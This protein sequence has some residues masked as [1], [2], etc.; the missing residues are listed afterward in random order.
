MPVVDY[1]EPDKKNK[2]ESPHPAGPSFQNDVEG[3]SS[4]PFP[5]LTLKSLD[6]KEPNPPK[7]EAEPETATD[8]VDPFEG[9]TLKSIGIKESDHPLEDVYRSG[10]KPDEMAA[11]I[12]YS[13]KTGNPVSAIL[14]DEKMYNAAINPAP[15]FDALEGR[16]PGTYEFV[17]GNPAHMA[18]SADSLSEMGALE[19][20]MTLWSEQYGYG[21]KQLEAH[22]LA[23]Q[24][25]TGE[26]RNGAVLSRAR[27]LL[28]DERTLRA[29][30]TGEEMLSATAEL[31]PMTVGGMASLARM[32]VNRPWQ[33]EAVSEGGGFISFDPDEPAHIHVDQDFGAAKQLFDPSEGNAGPIMFAY[34]QEA[35]GAFLE[36]M[37]EVDKHGLHLTMEQIEAGAHTVGL[38]N[39]ALESVQLGVVLKNIPG[40]KQLLS[41]AVR[42]TV[43][44]KLKDPAFWKVIGKNALGFAG[45]VGAEVGTEVLQEITNIAVAEF[46]KSLSNKRDGREFDPATFEEIKTRLGEIASKTAMGMPLMIGPGRAVNTT[47]DVITT[48]NAK[49]AKVA[50]REFVEKVGEKLSEMPVTER[51]PETVEEF[52]SHIGARHSIPEALYI[53]GEEIKILFQDAVES[54]TMTEEQVDTVLEEVGIKKDVL[55]E[56]AEKGKFVTLETPKIARLINTPVWEGVTQAVT[57]D[58]RSEISEMVENVDAAFENEQEQALWNK[59]QEFK[60]GLVESG[61][62]T[63]DK[64]RAVTELLGRYLNK[65]QKNYDADVIEYMDDL[66]LRRRPFSE[67]VAEWRELVSRGEMEALGFDEDGKPL[68]VDQVEEHFDPEVA[69]VQAQRMQQALVESLPEA[70]TGEEMADAVDGLIDDGVL[71]EDMVDNSG[72]WEW[73]EEKD[74]A[75]RQDVVDYLD[76]LIQA[77]G[78]GALF[79]NQYT[80]PPITLHD[81]AIPRLGDMADVFYIDQKDFPPPPPPPRRKRKRRPSPKIIKDQLQY[82]H[83]ASTADGY[84]I[85]FNEK[86]RNHVLKFDLARYNM[87]SKIKE[88]LEASV[89]GGKSEAEHDL[90]DVAAGTVKLGDYSLFPSLWFYTWVDLAGDLY[91]VRLQVKKLFT[92]DYVLYDVQPQKI[93]Q[94]SAARLAW[95]S[96]PSRT[97]GRYTNPA[98]LRIHELIENSKHAPPLPARPAGKPFLKNPDGKTPRGA[99]WK[100]GVERWIELFEKADVTTV[101]HELFHIFKDD[102]TAW[103]MK[104]GPDSRVYQDYEKACEFVG[105]KVGE[106]WT[107][108]QEERFAEAGE[109]YLAEGVAPTPELRGLFERLREMMLEV[110]TYVKNA[111]VDLTPE[112]REVFDRLLATDEDI[113]NAKLDLELESLYR[114]MKVQEMEGRVSDADLEE[115]DKAF[116]RAMEALPDEL[117]RRRVQELGEA[118]ARWRKEAKEDAKLDPRRTMIEEMKNGGGIDVDLANQFFDHDSVTAL[119]KRYPGLFKKGQGARGLDEWAADYGM[120]GDVALFEMLENL[121]SLKDAENQYVA[122]REA[123]WNEYYAGNDAITPE[124][125]DLLDIEIELLNKELYGPDSKAAPKPWKDI[126]KI[127]R[128]RTGQE[129]VGNLIREDVAL[130]ASLKARARDARN[131]Y[132]AGRKAAKEEAAAQTQELKAKFK[133]QRLEWLEKAKKEKM[134]QRELAIE[135]REK[136]RERRNLVKAREYFKRVFNQKP[137]VPGRQQ[138]IQYDYHQQIK[139]L[140]SRYGIGPKS[141]KPAPNM[142]GLADFINKHVSEYEIL[143][144]PQWILDDTGRPFRE[145]SYDAA[146]ELKDVVTNLVTLGKNH[147]KLIAGEMRR[148]FD[149][150]VNGITSTIYANHKAAPPE[151]F[152]EI[153]QAKKDGPSRLLD[154]VRNYYAQLIKVE[155]LTRRLDGFQDMGRVWSQIFLPLKKAEDAELKL[156]A[157]LWKDVEDAFSKLPKDWR[158]EWNTKT[159]K[160][161]G[162]DERLTRE[163][164]ICAALNS[165]NEG[166]FKALSAGMNWSEEQV[167]AIWNELTVEEWQLVKDLWTA[168]DQLFGPLDETHY[169][170]TGVRL[171]KVEGWEIQTKHGPVQGGYYPLVF[172]P[173]LSRKAEQ[174]D[175][176]KNLRDL[177]ESIYSKPDTRAGASYQRKGGKMPPLLSFGVLQAHIQ[178]VVH[179]ATHRAAVRDVQKLI[180]DERVRI[181]IERTVG[182]HYYRQLMPW[183]TYIARPEVKTASA[184]EELVGHVR[185]NTTV[186]LLGV[187]LSVA[188]KQFLS[189]TQTV[190]TIGPRAAWQGLIGFYS[191]PWACM[192]KIR[193]KSEFMKQR[194]KQWDRELKTLT[195]SFSPTGR[196]K[197]DQATEAFF[198]LI[199]VMDTAA[200]GPTWLGAYQKALRDGKAEADAVEYADFVVRTTQPTAAPKDLAHIQRG[201]EY[202]KLVTMFYTFFS[203]FHNRFDSAMRQNLTPQRVEFETVDGATATKDV[204]N[205]GGLANAWLWLVIIPAYMGLAI[206]NRDIPD[207]PEE[208]AGAMVTYLFGGMPILRDAVNHAVSGFEY[209]FSPAVEGG[210]TAGWLLRSGW[211]F[212]TGHAGDID[213]GLLAQNLTDAAGY[214]AGLPSKQAIATVKGFIYASNTPGLN[215]LEMAEAV[216]FGKPKRKE[217]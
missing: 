153:T 8:A 30:G 134:R 36:L 49:H 3:S 95:G 73:L 39:A 48:A 188:A 91:S 145:L 31:M 164:M 200:C 161:K 211:M 45:D 68:Q 194:G 57:F 157:K 21:K 76:E 168:I 111:G 47:V 173:R 11:V 151:S 180:A 14:S 26:N 170:M 119:I 150:A 183:L 165:G 144:V 115:Y 34:R 99:T 136:E 114:H 110:Y 19:R 92:G 169:K 215:P 198:Y 121:P 202:Q 101:P 13:N 155:F 85:R 217:D 90:N 9:L 58:P 126:K 20:K 18:V 51:S 139:A 195:R 191:N 2:N 23:F 108:E 172:D 196:S 184:L 146:M 79:S 93:T 142:P 71:D 28:K 186:A 209:T 59:L 148:D 137:A 207:D 15:D 82:L 132:F 55:E 37:D 35:G 189:F 89:L 75:T 143:N 213:G 103:A 199:G 70:G 63:P 162:I 185:R 193:E 204:M 205:W 208:I 175:I 166:N 140:L 187:K 50:A 97:H 16:A 113:A 131:A 1:V 190:H 22:E 87:S 112:I 33:L 66:N 12:R 64:A 147:Q 62:Y 38:I 203:V 171:W 54:G 46:Q 174:Q 129:K 42:K 192:E 40:A 102:L 178:E 127:I 176:E 152:E 56:A 163:Q 60:S 78:V 107:T 105:A 94:G 96:N 65:I 4:N 120:D 109:R 100:L 72:L 214:G 133:T 177:M 67:A 27:E 41:K 32:P 86:S 104:A 181:A 106:K 53:Q 156:G 206:N 88:I 130:K 44:Q 141:F 81:D 52:L 83:G 212:V 84:A 179:D 182:K 122:E 77:H 61:V 135:R 124:G 138:G 29:K 128:A 210:K 17:A 123:E 98:T 149:E 74:Q 69:Q 154:V 158:K 24:Y 167:S 6:M 118:Q 5:G 125:L 201:P 117:N 159:W 25:M 116:K 197:K 160:I 10:K 7:V 80:R 216:A 43:K